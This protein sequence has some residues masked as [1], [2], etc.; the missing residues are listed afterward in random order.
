MNIISYNYSYIRHVGSFTTK[1]I[2]DIRGIIDIMQTEICARESLLIGEDKDEKVMFQF[3][4]EGM[5]SNTLIGSAVF[6]TTDTIKLVYGTEKFYDILGFSTEEYEER[7]LLFLRTMHLEQ[8]V[9]VL[10]QAVKAAKTEEPEL[11]YQYEATNKTGKAI[12]ISIGIRF[13]ERV[14]DT[15]YYYVSLSSIDERTKE[16]TESIKDFLSSCKARENHAMMMIRIGN[17]DDVCEKY[18]SKFADAV[19]LDVSATIQRAFRNTDF[20]G[21]ISDNEFLIF[22]KNTTEKVASRKAEDLCGQIQKIYNGENE[23]TR[24]YSN[25]GL[26]YYPYDGTGY[27]ALLTHL[28][29]SL[30][31]AV[32]EGKDRICA[33]EDYMELHTINRDYEKFVQSGQIGTEKFDIGFLTFAF[34]LLSDAKDMESSINLLLDRLGNYYDLSSIWVMEEDIEHKNLQMCNGWKRGFG[35][36]IPTEE[37]PVGEDDMM[38]Q[39]MEPPFFCMEDCVNIKEE[40][41]KIFKK[42]NI[43]SFICTNFN[44]S[45]FGCSHVIF[46]DGKRTRKWSAQEKETIHE[47]G[48]LISVFSFLQKDKKRDKNQI[49]NLKMRDQLTGLYNRPAFCEAVEQLLAIYDG[50]GSYAFV[51]SDMNGFEYMNGNFGYEAGN[52]LLIDYAKRLETNRYSRVTCRVY[53]DYFLTLFYGEN[54]RQILDQ[55]KDMNQDF[56]MEQRKKYPLNNMSIAT[57]IC[58][59]RDIYLEENI[60]VMQMIENANMA[61]KEAK[62][63]RGSHTIIYEDALREELEREQHLAG[64][65]EDAMKNEEIELFLQPKFSLETRRVIGAEALVRW[66]NPDGTYNMPMDFIPVLEKAG[67]IIDLDFYVFEL[68]LK[69]LKKWKMEGKQVFP[70]SVNFSRVHT[71]SEDFVRRIIR[72]TDYYDIERRLI[73]I[74]ITESTLSDNNNRMQADMA[75]LQKAGFHVDIDDFGT[76][77]SSLNMLLRAPVDTVKMDKSFLVDV[78]ESEKQR[79]YLNCIAKLVKVADKEIIFEGVETEQQA[80]VIA[81]YGY[82]QVQGFLFGKPIPVEQFELTY[83]I[84]PFHEAEIEVAG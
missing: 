79:E 43:K 76:G 16:C 26:A 28:D 38:K 11:T 84:S 75:M 49:Q 24:L 27:D 72:L 32:S 2:I 80:K 5:L 21:R 35:V 6:A 50:T 37:I 39:L 73:E 68:V 71:Q 65:L 10:R 81:D 64:R 41:R 40:Y 7:A 52:Q 44:E 29:T 8:D 36:S 42:K 78:A 67:Y 12:W 66:R 33:Y 53:S 45:L 13:M 55:V 30:Y 23:K 56:L 4:F 46:S 48:R 14:G 62:N 59:V 83:M 69:N 51:Y 9:F 60:D 1:G 31:Y 15:S 57:G 3:M 17:L 70:I 63:K 61:R 47:L 20:M 82:T 34:A 74:E 77:Y 25:I 58:C 18:G 54:P 22:M 19:T